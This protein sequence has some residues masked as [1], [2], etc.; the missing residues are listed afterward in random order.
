V[1]YSGEVLGRKPRLCITTIEGKKRM[2]GIDRVVLVEG[3]AITM[4]EYL[5]IT[6]L[7]LENE[8]RIHPQ[9]CGLRGGQMLLDAISEVRACGDVNAV[10]RMF[11]LIK[12]KQVKR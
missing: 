5:L 1:D 4:K 11:G 9:K 2:F 8:D 12:R 10:C 3:K 6:K 7:L